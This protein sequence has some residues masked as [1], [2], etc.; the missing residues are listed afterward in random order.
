MV[1]LLNIYAI[2]DLHLS[3]QTPVDPKRWDLVTTAKP[4]HIFHDAWR[5]HYRKIYDNWLEMIRPGDLVLIPGDISWAMRLPEARFDLDFL[6]L[7]P[8]TIV[9]VAGNHDYWWQSLSRVRRELPANMRVIQNDHLLFGGIAVCGSR[10]WNCPGGA[11]FKEQDLKIYHR[12]LIRMENSLKQAAD[13]SRIV[14]MT[15]FMPTNERHEKNELI[16]LFIQYRV[17]KVVY[18]HLHA[19]S[20]KFRLPEQLWGI[21]FHLV[22]ADYLHFAP[23]LIIDDYAE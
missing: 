12:E 16:E 18:G 8:G 20:A 3:F 11:W 5:E 10:G 13:A 22:S 17:S 7:L 15:H 4:M 21:D 19:A 1:I 2:G 23:R 9:G 14:V 6:G